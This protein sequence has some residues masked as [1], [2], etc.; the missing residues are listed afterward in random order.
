MRKGVSRAVWSTRR[1]PS[2]HACRAGR[3]SALAVAGAWFAYK[4]LDALRVGLGVQVLTGFFKTTVDFTACAADNLV[5]AAEDP[6]YDALSE[7][8]VGPIFAPSANLGVT[9]VTSRLLRVAVSGQAPFLVS[10]PGSVSVRLPTAPEFE[11]AFQQG[12]GARISFELPPVV[13]L[14][15]ELRPLE[16]GDL[17]IEVAYVREFWSTHQ[18]IEVTPRDILLYGVTGFPSPFGVSPISLPRGGEDSN[19][20]RAGGEYR[21]EVGGYH[22]QVRAGLAYETSGIKEAY[23]SPLTIDSS[24]VSSSI[25]G[26]LYIGRHWRMDGVFSHVF[27]SDVRVSPQEAAVP[28]VN[29]V[30]G[31]P[32][33]T[34]SINGGAYSARADVVGVGLEYRF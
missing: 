22:L 19:S 1:P 21:F 16:G 31:N 25:G 32:T 26:S 23:V 6:K 34:Q 7:L 15:F 2:W 14:G 10:S 11:H 29:P 13:R 4:P 27:A 5:C 9:W 20:L 24:K 8:K 17:R 33:Q 3:G 30:K 28:R 18:S 12:N